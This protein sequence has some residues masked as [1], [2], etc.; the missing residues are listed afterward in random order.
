MPSLPIFPEFNLAVYLRTNRALRG[1]GVINSDLSKS[2]GYIMPD[3]IKVAL[4]SHYQAEYNG[5]IAGQVDC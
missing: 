2:P 1:G 3:L 5:T 4:Q